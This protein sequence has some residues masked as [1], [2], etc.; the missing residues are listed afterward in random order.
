MSGRVTDALG[1]ARTEAHSLVVLSHV[2]GGDEQPL[3]ELQ[4]VL[5]VLEH[6]RQALRHAQQRAQG[7]VT[8]DLNQQF[9]L[10][11]STRS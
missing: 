8:D 2:E 4:R 3:G 6:V 11:F 7:R 5:R 1:T 9:Q 10:D